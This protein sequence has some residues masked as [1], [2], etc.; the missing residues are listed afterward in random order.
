MRGLQ[1]GGTGSALV[2]VSW[3]SKADLARLAEGLDTEDTW[4]TNGV[5]MPGG[6]ESCWSA[7]KSFLESWG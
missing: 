2:G 1:A 7:V 5:R 3:R 4:D 6:G